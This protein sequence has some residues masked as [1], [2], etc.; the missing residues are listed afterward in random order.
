MKSLI[1]GLQVF[2]QYS[3]QL[4][5]GSFNPVRLAMLRSEKLPLRLPLERL[6]QIHMIIDKDAWVCIDSAFYDMPLL[7]W[8]DF[9]LDGRDSL[10]QP[11]SCELLHYQ[12]HALLLQDKIL[13]LTIE[14]ANRLVRQ[15]P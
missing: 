14:E 2:E 11:V 15:W 9:R 3:T 13:A 8:T 12:A 6:H 4:D 10:I 7:A 5:A 1:R